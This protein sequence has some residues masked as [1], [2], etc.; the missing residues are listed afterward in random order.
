MID[1]CLICYENN[2]ES[3]I[4]P[5]GHSEFCNKCISN[6]KIKK[7][8]ICKKKI[9]FIVPITNVYIPKKTR[10]EKFNNY[11]V[12]SIKFFMLIIY[13]IMPI[14]FGREILKV[15]F[16]KDRKQ[17]LIS[18][19]LICITMSTGFYFVKCI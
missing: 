1:K 17:L 2:F 14:F 4:S 12:L 7:C 8:P 3:V 16:N 13:S 10:F 9:D 6:K 11:Y 5:C 15:F 18:S 19:F